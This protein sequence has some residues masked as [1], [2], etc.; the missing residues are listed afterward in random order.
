MQHPSMM[1]DPAKH[2]LYILILIILLVTTNLNQGYDH[3]KGGK[4]N[5]AG[6]VLA[7]SLSQAASNILVKTDN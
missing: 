1:T 5:L 7:G 4:T 2:I 6:P 3:I